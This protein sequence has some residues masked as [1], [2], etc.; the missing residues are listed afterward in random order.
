MSYFTDNYSETILV[1]KCDFTLKVPIEILK[2]RDTIKIEVYLI[3]EID[4][5]LPW[6]EEMHSKYDIGENFFIRRKDILAISNTLNYSYN[7]SGD[8]IIKLRG[9]EDKN[10]KF[11]KVNL[12]SEYIFVSVSK[13]FNKNYQ[14]IIAKD[15][16][17]G[18]VKEILNSSLVYL[19]LVNVF[20][21][22]LDQDIRDKCR[23]YRWYNIINNSFSYKDRD[24]EDI[25]DELDYSEIDEIY[26][27]VEEFMNYN[28]EKAI[29]SAGER[30]GG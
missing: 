15:S 1:N 21:K 30:I 14:K 16:K 23:N 29:I 12:H 4:M 3:S 2:S 19:V 7:I 27:L 26:K 25:L 11:I 24:L 9:I 13:E 28:Y 17:R 20:L 10:H 18:Y 5:E 6:N 8:T 22:L